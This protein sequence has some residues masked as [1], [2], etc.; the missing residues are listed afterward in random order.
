MLAELLTRER[1]ANVCAAAIDVLA[2]AGRPEALQALADCESRF[3]DEPFL[4]FAIGIARQR[5]H[6]Q[7]NSAHG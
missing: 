6:S 1:E 2:E 3:S 5:I 4:T 7:S